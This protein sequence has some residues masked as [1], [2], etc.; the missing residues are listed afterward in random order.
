M[1]RIDELSEFTPS[2][3]TEL[4]D[5][6]GEIFATFARERRILLAEGK[7]PE[8]L[9]Q[10]IISGEDANFYQ[11]SGIDPMGVVRSLLKNIGRDSPIG[12]STL[13]MQLARKLY[14]TPEKT[15]RRKIEE[16]FLT[17]EIEKKFSK[18]QILT[19][20]G[21]VMYLG[22]GNHG[23]EAASRN[24]F[25]KPAAELDVHEAATLV[26]ILQRPSDYSPYR[27]PDRVLS[28]RDYVL[29]RMGVEG[30]LDDAALAAALAE[31]LVVRPSVRETRLAPYFAEEIRKDLESR[32]GSDVLLENG[33]TVETTLDRRMQLAAEAALRRGLLELD[34]R[35]GFR[36]PLDRIEID[37]PEAVGLDTWATLRVE[38]GVWAQGVVLRARGRVADVKIG[39]QIYPLGP[40]G[41]R[42]TGRERPGDLLRP[43]D[44]A[45]FRFGEPTAEGEPPTLF[46]EQEPKLEGAV[47]VLES[48]TGAI[49]AMVGGWDFERSKFNRVTQA[50][51]QPGSGF[52]PFVW[53][54]ALEAGYTLAD[55]FFDAPT[56]F[57]GTPGLIDYSPRNFYRDYYGIVTLRRAMEVSANVTAVKLL[58]LVGAAQVVEFGRRCGLRSELPPYPSLA[59]GAAELSPLEMAAAYATFA[60]QGLHVEPHLIERVTARDGR[61]LEEHRTRASKAM[62]P[63]IAHLMT[64]LLSGVIDRGTGKTAAAIPLDLAGKTGTTDDYSDAWFIGYTP[65]LTVLSWVGYDVKKR[66]GRNMTGA[67]AALP[68]WRAVIE[69][70]LEEGWIQEGETFSAPPGLSTRPVDY[71]TGLLAAPGAPAVIQESFLEG[72]EPVFSWNERWREVMDLPWY[73]QR[74]YYVAK[75]SERMP[76][77]VLDWTPVIEAWTAKSEAE[78]EAEESE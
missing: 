32:Y 23:M 4:H 58:D 57:E 51:R 42:W 35:F 50:H 52:K 29:R 64:R 59:L 53:G 67:V 11:H 19:L 74:F 36:G 54:A 5:R 38:P 25:G 44:V 66:I 46:L 77:D 9:A 65:R 40:D 70:G 1:P 26:G 45:W 27:R 12:G 69:R 49:R 18:E 13:T 33:L 2:L 76:E 20:Y 21:N 47:V 28:R 48:A 55:T 34:H 43:G 22:H 6:E 15:W 31:P 71:L 24:F 7:V 8:V 37:A 10:A 73:Q 14:L 30:Y 39:D 68:I 17:V 41:I 60:N 72:T 75:A 61:V 56:A 62:E 78:A 63:Q 3:I 16:A